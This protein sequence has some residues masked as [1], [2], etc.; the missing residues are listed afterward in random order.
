LI[1]FTCFAVGAVWG[2]LWLVKDRS[3][4]RVKELI[5]VIVEALFFPTWTVQY[6]SCFLFLSVL[7]VCWSFSNQ[8][9]TSSDSIEQEL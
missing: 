8:S 4:S 3:D 9:M 7:D 1:C 2:Q 5:V 6:V